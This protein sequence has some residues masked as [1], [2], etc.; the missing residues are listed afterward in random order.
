MTAAAFLQTVQTVVSRRVDP[1]DEDVVTFGTFDAGTARNII[2]DE[3]RLTGTC[4]AYTMKV[5]KR[6]LREIGRVARNT[7]RAMGGTAEIELGGKYPAVVNDARATAFLAET[8][9][10]TLGKSNVVEAESAMGGEDFAYFLEE[11]PGA[12]FRLG[13]GT[14]N[15]PGH[16]PT[17]EFDDRALK[18][19]MLVMSLLTLRWLE[20]H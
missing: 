7:A 4:R 15:R 11:V 1:L 19:G 5:M 16:N 8:A 18:T 17:F 9:V 13:N 6:I 12:F 14:P 10:R 20:E 3:A 2:P